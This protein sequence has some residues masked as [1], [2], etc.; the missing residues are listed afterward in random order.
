[1]GPARKHRDSFAYTLVSF[2]VLAYAGPLAL[3]AI[4][5]GWQPGMHTRRL[6]CAGCVLCCVDAAGL[7]LNAFLG[8][9]RH[10]RDANTFSS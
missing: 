9:Q 10:A 6:A 5:A 3:S 2:P 8:L 7:G 1:M 4:A